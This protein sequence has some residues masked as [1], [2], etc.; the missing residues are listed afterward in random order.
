MEMTATL[1]RANR[2]SGP[3]GV[4]NVSMSTTPPAVAMLAR[5]YPGS[6]GGPGGMAKGIP[7]AKVLG[8]TGVSCT[9]T[10]FPAVTVTMT[11]PRAVCTVSRTTQVSLPTSQL[12]AAR[13]GDVAKAVGTPAARPA[14]RSN[15]TSCLAGPAGGCGREDGHKGLRIRHSPGVLEVV[16]T[17]A[18]RWMR[19]RPMWPDRRMK[20]G[21]SAVSH[22]RCQVVARD[23]VGQPGRLADLDAV[24]CGQG[25][26]PRRVRWSSGE[27]LG[28]LPEEVLEAGRAD[29][30]DHAGGLLA[31]VPHGV[32]LA[33]RLGDVAARAQDDFA[34]TRAEADL[35]FGDDGVLVLEGVHVRYHQRTDGKWVLD[36]GHGAVGLGA[37]E[38]ELDADSSQPAGGAL[39]RVHDGQGWRVGQAG[40]SSG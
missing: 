35:A 20:A 26:E 15:A 23:D 17:R 12:V 1:G 25:H 4:R 18:V 9:V 36:D 6:P 33:P 8:A 29:D 21:S 13:A 10:T 37:Q 28:Q 32:H 2:L 11:G 3:G 34:V 7:N 38:L 27:G 14:T 5:A 39:A 24:P 16:T 30:L 22:R 40:G 31:G 19:A